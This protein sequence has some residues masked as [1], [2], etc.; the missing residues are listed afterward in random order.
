MRTI[1]LR[2]AAGTLTILIAAL[3]LIV[4]SSALR[5]GAADHL[6]APTVRADGRIDINDLYVFQGQNSS[7]TV[8][9]M[10]VS[11]AA[12]ITTGI[13]PRRLPVLAPS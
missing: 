8:L 1:A 9:A 6:D 7:H 10:T 3:A 5:V 2:S 11:P 4:G 13:F 12:G